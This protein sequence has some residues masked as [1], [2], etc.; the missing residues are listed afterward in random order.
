MTC[1][2]PMWSVLENVHLHLK[3]VYILFL[4]TCPQIRIQSNCSIISSK[5]SAAFLNFCLDNLSIVI[6]GNIEFTHSYYITVVVQLLSCVKLF[7]TL[8]S[9]ARQAFLS[10]TISQSLL[11]LMSIESVLPS[12]QFI[13]CCPLLLLPS[14]FPSIRV[15]TNELA[16]LIGW[17]KYWGFKC[18]ISPS[19]KYLWWIS[20]RIF[21]L[22]ADQGTLKT[23]LS[24]HI[25]K[26]SIFS[27]PPFSWSNS[28]NHTWL[29][30]KPYLWLYGPL[31]AKW[32]LCFLICCLGL[33]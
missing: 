1:R 22:L 14:I 11:K 23:L 20:F 26:A 33:A 7:G 13:L 12:N 18:S 28:H 15:F 16:L 30:E 10:F 3:W 24:Q 5:T 21:D 17:P 32:C 27:A 8:W 9:A 6:S 2:P 19:S 25:S 4:I 31:L 29:L